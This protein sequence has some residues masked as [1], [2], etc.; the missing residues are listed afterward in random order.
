MKIEIK[1]IFGNLLFEND[2]ENNSVKKTIEKAVHEDANLIG[3]NLRGANLIGAYL[4][5][6]NLEGANLEGANLIDANLEGANL[7]DANLE[8][9]IKIPFYCKW[10]HGIT[11]GMVHIGCEKRTIEDWDKFFESDS[12]IQT[13]RNTH[14]FNQIQAVYLAYRA[15]IKHLNN[16]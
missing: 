9:A 14:D 1:S 2:C 8:G 10:S 12:V 15:Y 11:D 16:K 6:A 3:A 7:I 4:I 5:D 13:P